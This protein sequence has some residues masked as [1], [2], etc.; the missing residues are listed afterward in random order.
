[1]VFEVM[2]GKYLRLV[3]QGLGLPLE[4]F[5]Q[6]RQHFLRGIRECIPQATKFLWAEKTD[7]FLFREKHE[8]AQCQPI[9]PT[10]MV[11]L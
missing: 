5:E 6:S 7:L 10:E 4:A 8:H 11:V 3:V 9:F 2:R 1:M